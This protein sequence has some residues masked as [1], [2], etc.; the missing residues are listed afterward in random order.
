MQYG[1]KLGGLNMGIDTDRENYSMPGMPWKVWWSF[2]MEKIGNAFFQLTVF[3]VLAPILMLSGLI[4]LFWF[5]TGK[6]PR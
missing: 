1:I 3:V 4:V 5:V 2:Q 6:N